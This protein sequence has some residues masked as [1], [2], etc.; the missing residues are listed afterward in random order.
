M[1]CIWTMPGIMTLVALDWLLLEMFALVFE[2]FSSFHRNIP[3]TSKPYP[4]QRAA[5]PFAAS[6]MGATGGPG[7]QCSPSVWRLKTAQNQDA[8]A[9]PSV[10]IASVGRSCEYNTVEEM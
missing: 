3:S 6:W 5:M 1:L 7:S 8:P 4:M 9:A 10:P 2:Y